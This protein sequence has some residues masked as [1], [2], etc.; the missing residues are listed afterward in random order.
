M[1]TGKVSDKSNQPVTGAYVRY[2]PTQYLDTDFN[3]F[4]NEAGSYEMHIIPGDDY[5]VEVFLDHELIFQK[6]FNIAEEHDP[7]IVI[8]RDLIIGDDKPLVAAK[9]VT[10][11]SS[12][13]LATILNNHIK[14]EEHHNIPPIP[15]EVSPLKSLGSKFRKGHK[16]LI[17]NVYFGTGNADLTTADE[18]ALQELVDLMT[19]YTH[20]RIEIGGHTDNVGSPSSNLTLTRII[21]RPPI[22]GLIMGC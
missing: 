14:A 3:G 9:D 12:G 22:L 4:S 6:T 17:H 21:H 20:L 16:A 13:K 7:N 18:E 5:R 10:F 8:Q 15:R 1:I 19:E 2:H 11:Y